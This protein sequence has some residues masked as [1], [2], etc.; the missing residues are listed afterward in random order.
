MK[1]PYIKAIAILLAILVLANF[2]LMIFGKISSILFWIIMIVGAV[3]A[4][5]VLPNLRKI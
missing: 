1:H 5:K 3:M 2:F 4:Y